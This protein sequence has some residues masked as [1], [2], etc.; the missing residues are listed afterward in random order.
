[1]S[2]ESDEMREEYDIRGG[3]RGKYY[4]RY[5]Q[6]K[7]I[8]FPDSPLVENRTASTT[9]VGS[10][11]MPASYRMPLVSSRIVVGDLAVAR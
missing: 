6:G 9:Q 3:I 11:T 5:V 2:Q 8:T 4:R 1:M 10:I 7:Q